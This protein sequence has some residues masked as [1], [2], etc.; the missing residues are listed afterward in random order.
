MEVK[1]SEAVAVFVSAGVYTASEWTVDRIR[2]KI[3]AGPL[4]RYFMANLS[5]I[6][7][8]TG[9]LNGMIQAQG[10]REIITVVED[11]NP[12]EDM[13]KKA[14]IRAAAVPRAKKGKPPKPRPDRSVPYAERRK[15][16][17]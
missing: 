11:R 7:P 14:Q 12:S 4:E 16:W 17:K 8:P 13:A 2:E 6:G 15:N 10:R 5:N 9:I 1:A 3:D